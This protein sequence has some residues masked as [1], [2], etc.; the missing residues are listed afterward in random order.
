L[1]YYV[2]FYVGLVDKVKMSLERKN[3]FYGIFLRIVFSLERKKIPQKIFLGLFLEITP[4][5]IP[6]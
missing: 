1:D 2:F 5:I 4:G 3:I 6:E